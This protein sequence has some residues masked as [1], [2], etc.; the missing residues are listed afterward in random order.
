MLI[1]L[2]FFIVAWVAFNYENHKAMAL[3]T[4]RLAAAAADAIP[5]P[6]DSTTTTSDDESNIILDSKT[7]T[8]TGV[9]GRRMASSSGKMIPPQSPELFSGVLEKVDTGCF[10]DGECYVVVGGKHVTVL[11][12]W[13]NEIVGSVRNGEGGIGELDKHVGTNMVVFANKLSKNSYTLY[14]S[15]DYYVELSNR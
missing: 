9:S 3:H 15:T 11:W 8:T 2:T 1:T 7:E 10:V 4:A 14:G 13:T 12:G 5:S 6:P